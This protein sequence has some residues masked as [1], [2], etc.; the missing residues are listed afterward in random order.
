MK[1]QE[2]FNKGQPQAQPAK[3]EPS[4][5]EPPQNPAVSKKEAA[6]PS[7]KTLTTP[8]KNK[9]TDKC[10]RCGDTGFLGQCH[11]CSLGTGVGL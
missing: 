7:Q 6:K 1:S 8:R 5:T 4:K 11:S 9:G 10:P 2:V 3:A